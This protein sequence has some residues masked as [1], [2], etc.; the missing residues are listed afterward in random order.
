[1]A[2]S[3]QPPEAQTRLA[4][5]IERNARPVVATLRQD[6]GAPSPMTALSA[7]RTT[8]DA[9][10]HAT[11]VLVQQSRTAG[12]TWQEIGELLAI[13]RQAAQQRFGQTT[14]NAVQA[15]LAGR[16]AG[17]V[18]KLNSGAWQ[19][20]AAGFDQVMRA[21]LSPE[22]LRTTWEAIV[23]SAGSLETTGPSSVVQR[24][25]YRIVD[26]PLLFTHG[27]M[28]ARVVFNHDER[29]SGLFV[30]LPDAP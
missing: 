16:A 20:V 13:T 19:Q 27:P 11:Q 17:I 12:H 24:G 15:Q 14:P 7:A 1:M 5:V 28:K 9:I 2:D 10:E 23:A 29:I 21:E 4:L 26:V 3:Q 8:A 22:R 30:L 25:P 18:D 6:A